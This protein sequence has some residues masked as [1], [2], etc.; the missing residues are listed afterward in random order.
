MPVTATINFDYS[1]DREEVA[2]D[3]STISTP[4]TQLEFSGTLGAKDSA[5]EVQLRAQNLAEWGDFINILRGADVA[6]VP[7]AG[8]VDWTGRILGPLGGPTFAGHLHATEA[9]Y[10]DY[11]WNSI[12]GDLEYSPDVFRLTKTAIVRGQTS[13]VMDLSLQLDGSWSFEPSSTWALQMHINRAPSQDV[14][15]MFE[16]KYP[17]TGSVERRR[18]WQWHASRSGY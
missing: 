11:Y 1:N 3:Q 16:T 5:L 17:V 13:A 14:Q 6:P 8:Q 12:E 4:N 9:H 7:V 18:A 15:E 10:A 2:V